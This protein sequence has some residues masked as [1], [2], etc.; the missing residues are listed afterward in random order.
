[1]VF[2]VPV[3]YIKYYIIY[4]YKTQKLFL[5][6]SFYAFLNRSSDCDEIWYIDRL[7]LGEEDRLRSVAKKYT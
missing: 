4:T 1:M 2:N 7:N 6:M 5:P 3:L